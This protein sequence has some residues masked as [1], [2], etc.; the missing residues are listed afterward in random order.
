MSKQGKTAI[1]IAVVVVLTTLMVVAITS[2]SGYTNKWGF[3]GNFFNRISAK[4]DDKGGVVAQN[5][6]SK[7]NVNKLEISFIDE[8][9]II[10]ESTD[11]TLRIEQISSEN[12]TEERKMRVKESN[13][14]LEAYVRGMDFW[15]GGCTPGVFKSSE[16][17][18]YIPEQTVLDIEISTVSGRISDE[19]GGDY[20]KMECNTTS[21]EIDVLAGNMSKGDFNTV[22][23]GVRVEMANTENVDISTISGGVDFIGTV[24]QKIDVSTTSG[25]V[26]LDLGVMP[27]KVSV[28][29]ISGGVKIVI[30]QNS[31]FD[32]EYDSISGS[33]NSDFPVNSGNGGGKISVNTT[34]GS[35]D[36]VKK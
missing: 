2:F 16:I 21:G 1:W 36:I 32:T 35:C 11:N 6:V 23:G 28:D 9:V 3:N 7:G 8:S 31:V 22:S 34:S 25:G 15:F 4:I 19:R 13:G 26:D 14:K 10:R 33:L 30:P 5:Y 20:T 18:A 29:S 12:L 27:S 24:A 17:I